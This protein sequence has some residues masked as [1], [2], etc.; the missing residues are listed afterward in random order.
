MKFLNNNKQKYLNIDL[1]LRLFKFSSCKLQILFLRTENSANRTNF[2]NIFLI[3]L[4]QFLLEIFYF[5]L[6][7]K[8][9]NYSGLV[10]DM[11]QLLC[12]I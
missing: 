12:F 10:S 6:I 9:D 1:K 3:F 5:F 8:N 7:V 11:G 2:P 4:Q